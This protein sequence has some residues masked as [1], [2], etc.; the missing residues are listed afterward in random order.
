MFA[1]STVSA[2][3]TTAGSTPTTI[4]PSPAITIPPAWAGGDRVV[5]P[6]ADPPPAHAVGIV[7]AGEGKMMA[8]IEPAMV[9]MAERFEFADVDHEAKVAVLDAG[10]SINHVTAGDAP[11]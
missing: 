4:S 2:T 7:V 1:S 5:I 3:P 8:G 6:H 10:S 9:G 11:F